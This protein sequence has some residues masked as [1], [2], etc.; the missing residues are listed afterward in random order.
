MITVRTGVLEDQVWVEIADNGCGIT[1]ENLTRV[2]DPF[3]TTKP[4]GKGVGLGLSTAFGVVRQHGGETS[5]T[6]TVGAGSIFRVVLPVTQAHRI[7]TPASGAQL[8][9]QRD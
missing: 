2:F 3:F 9:V 5:V 7:E 1:P 8:G 6:S 4:M